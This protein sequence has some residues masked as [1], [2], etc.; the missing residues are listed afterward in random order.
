MSRT[1]ALTLDADR[2]LYFRARRSHL[3]GDGA[4]SVE[5]A[6][7]AILGA[8]AQQV[9]PALFA[10][11]QR[12]RPARGGDM[13][14]AEEVASALYQGRRLVHTWGQRDTLHL[15]HPED[16]RD[17][18]VAR[19]QWSPGGRRGVMPD[20]R[21]VERGL[22]LLHGAGRPISRTDVYPVLGTA[23]LEEARRFVEEKAP[24]LDAAR[25]AAGRVLWCLAQRGDVC[26][27][28]KDGAEQTYTARRDG[29]PQ[30]PW[31]LVEGDGLD[32]A[33]R[34]TRRYLSVH[35]PATVRDLAHFWGSTVAAAR[36][37][38]ER[39]A[40]SEDLLPVTV[41]GREELWA[42]AEDESELRVKAPRGRTE[43]PV[44]MLPLWDTLLMAHADKTW[45]TPM[46]VDEKRIWRKA[47]YV[48][49]V[50]VARGRFVAVWTQKKMARRV[51]VEI[52]PL[53]GWKTSAHAPGVRR[54]ARALAMHLG[55]AD[56]E[57]VMGR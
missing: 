41:E 16:W 38:L 13:P 46:A 12:A 28:A 17:I 35:G 19:A 33:V 11:A 57:V 55:V 32:A 4:G 27:G 51:R 50:V 2:V 15:Y 31:P 37:W 10:L 26:L 25:F 6:A 34:W 7:R 1:G 44:R 39:L 45:T 49:A 29:F 42:L 24:S 5:Q 48:A 22:E 36:R 3:A 47:A 30:L 23:F 14:S 43:W 53:S 40:E 21:T 54:E 20:D 56:A 9:P 8:Q 52:E 18:V